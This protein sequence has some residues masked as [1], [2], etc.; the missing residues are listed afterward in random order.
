MQQAKDKMKHL[1]SL[2][3]H[4]VSYSLCFDKNCNILTQLARGGG[5]GSVDI[6]G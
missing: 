5:G 4:C 2:R 3:I 1:V 6:F